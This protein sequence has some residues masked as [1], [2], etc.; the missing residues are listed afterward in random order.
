MPDHRTPTI[1]P[2]NRG[3]V[4]WQTVQPLHPH[5]AFMCGCL[6]LP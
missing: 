5:Q 4:Q 2:P 6:A 1:V 3:T